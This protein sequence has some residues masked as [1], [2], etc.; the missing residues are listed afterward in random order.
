MLRCP[1]GYLIGVCAWLSIFVPKTNGADNPGTWNLPRLAA[2]GAK[3]NEAAAKVNVKPGTNVVVLDEEDSYVFD[4]EGKAVH[5]HYL[6]Y[7][8]FTQKGVEGWDSISLG[9]EPWHEERPTVRA[10]VVTPDN[11]VH[12]LDPKTITDSPARDEDEKTYGDGRVLRAPLPAI[13]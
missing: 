2:E 1:S 9:W 3:V 7:K 4:E 13:A 10:R 5:T 11:A 12:P 6:V 8:V